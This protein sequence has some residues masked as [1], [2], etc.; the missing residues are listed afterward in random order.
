MIVRKKD[1]H[2]TWLDRVSR[3]QTETA[4][5]AGEWPVLCREEFSLLVEKEM[6][7]CERRP[8]F[9]EFAIVLVDFVNSPPLSN[10]L[11]CFLTALRK[12]LRIIDEIGIWRE[13][14]AVFLP[15]TG[16]EGAKHV[17]NAAIEIGRQYGLEFESDIQVFPWDDQVIGKS[18]ELNNDVDQHMDDRK[19]ATD[20][21]SAG[22]ENAE[23]SETPAPTFVG[24]AFEMIESLPTPFWKRLMDLA[25]AATGLLLLSPLLAVVIVAIRLDSRGPVLFIQKRE[26]KDGRV[27]SIFKFRTMRNDAERVQSQLRGRNEQ[28]G[29]AFKI[30]NDPRVTQVGKYL[31]KTCIDELPQLLNVLYGDMS[32]VGPRPLPVGESLAAKTWQRR[33]LQVLPGMTCTW[34]IDGGRDVSFDQWMRMDL[35]YIRHRS[36]FLDFKLLSRTFWVVLSHRGSV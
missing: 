19:L 9:R 35:D 11:S 8:H 34:Q 4:K 5:S 1:G 7:R 26:G 6:A 27:F 16:R 14:L 31:R 12:R 33:R 15:E 21:I 30:G 17:A 24:N 13:T 22:E 18:N 28:D 10:E 20:R 2:G 25:G 36:I 32:L 29:P 3:H 23:P